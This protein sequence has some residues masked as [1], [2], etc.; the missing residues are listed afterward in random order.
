MQTLNLLPVTSYTVMDSAACTVTT[1]DG[2][3]LTTCT[4]GQQGYFATDETGVTV[5]STDTARVHEVNFN[6]A[7]G[8]GSGGGSSTVYVLGDDGTY[9][10]AV[11]ATTAEV[12]RPAGETDWFNFRLP[13]HLHGNNLHHGAG[14]SLFAQ[15]SIVSSMS[16]RGFY[17]E[18][19]GT[20]IVEL[21]SDATGHAYMTLNGAAV[22]TAVGAQLLPLPSDS[23]A[24]LQDGR[25]YEPT[26]GL[27]DWDLSGVTVA[28]NATAEIRFTLPPDVAEGQPWGVTFPA[29]WLWSDGDT[30]DATLD[31]PVA[32]GNFEPGMRYCIVV[33]NDNG[34]VIARV[35]TK[36]KTA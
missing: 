7:P 16:A 32:V 8:G 3:G 15:G 12:T 23:A 21:D 27:T 24:E 11:S 35:A 31:P 20:R 1:A 29:A 9:K 22:L 5:L 13:V 14:A 18:D 17:V 34:T 33:R 10:I 2:R 28:P 6:A 25:V 19:G 30:W 4:A 26:G 36:L